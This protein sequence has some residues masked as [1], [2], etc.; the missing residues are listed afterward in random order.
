MVDPEGRWAILAV[1]CGCG[2][3]W[4][5]I[6]TAPSN[7][8]ALRAWMAHGCDPEEGPA[9][10]LRSGPWQEY[11]LEGAYPAGGLNYG[12]GGQA[13]RLAGR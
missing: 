4:T 5:V 13:L 2:H 12:S 10:P 6:Q 8:A 11:R 1:T 9:V 7:L 3:R